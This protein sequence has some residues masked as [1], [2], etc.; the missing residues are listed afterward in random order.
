MRRFALALLAAALAAPLAAQQPANLTGTWTIST[1]FFGSTM[2]WQLHLTDTAGHL[3]GDLDGDKVEGTHDGSHVKFVAT[4]PKGGYE[5]VTGTLANNSFAGNLIWLRES[6]SADKAAS[7]PYTATLQPAPRS[8]PPQRLEFKPTVFYRQ[9][10][11]AIAPV[12]HL[13]PG[14]TIH[15]TTVDAGGTD[16]HGIVRS[17]GG[18][19]ET[20]PFFIETAMPGDT[21]A[22]H[23]LHLK[24]NRE[25]AISD[26]GLDPR[27]LNP[28][29]SVRT[30]DVGDDTL[31]WKLDLEHNVAT[32]TRPGDHLKQFTVP[33]HPMLGCIAT[34][35]RPGP[36]FPTG[37]SGDWGGNM[38]F[39][40][41]VEGNT[42]YLPVSVPGALLFFGD[43]HALQGDGELNGNALETSM[44]VELS[45]DIIH[46]HRTP[47]PRIESPTEIMAMGLEGS[48]DDAIKSAT[49]N[50]AHWLS[51]TYKLSPSEI[52]QVLGTL[53]EFRISEVADRNA[54]IVLKLRKDRLATIQPDAPKP[55][56]T[57]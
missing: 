30:K 22:V 20:G 37:D 38:D 1:D 19:P 32:T 8:G 45:V 33:F 4:D 31:T 28:D 55:S 26:D 12:A 47:S 17:A 44:D 23:I 52:A 49:N 11:A 3:T 21:L 9:F 10:S 56:P 18:N 39:N 2:Y 13:W 7:H 40:E 50:M 36:A 54:G 29:L 46:N 41:V 43:A 27:V 51:D 25:T 35:P 57:K 24:P 48:L 5:D 42:V 6:D 14:D 16:E 15:T 53:A 34:A